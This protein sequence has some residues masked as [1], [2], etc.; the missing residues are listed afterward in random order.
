MEPSQE[1]N[2]KSVSTS[3]HLRPY[4][5]ARVY[6]PPDIPHNILDDLIDKSSSLLIEHNI[7]QEGVE[8][9]KKLKHH[10]DENYEPYWHVVCGRNFGCY[11]I[12][13][14]RRFAYFYIGSTSFLVYK[15]G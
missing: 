1:Q 8:I 11:S 13:E 9:A 4:K 10:M 6:W 2:E 15:S 5:G 14:S 12:H 3:D 7:D